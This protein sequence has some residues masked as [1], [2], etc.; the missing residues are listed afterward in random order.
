MSGDLE[1]DVYDTLAPVYLVVMTDDREV[2]GCVRFLPTTG[3]TML[4]DTFGDLLAGEP[5]PHSERIIE[6]SRFCVDTE[7][8]AGVARNGLRQA[9]FVLFAGMIEWA[10]LVG[11]EAIVTVTDQRLERILRRAGWPLQTIGRPQRIGDT[12]AVAGL[13]SCSDDALAAVCRNGGLEPPVLLDLRSVP[14]AA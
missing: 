5:M 7:R 13:L 11:A 3:P 6:S 4:A 1:L 10:R 9:T 8:A 2:I 12:T 14:T